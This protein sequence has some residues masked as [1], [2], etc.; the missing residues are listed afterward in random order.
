MRHE[1]GSAGGPGSPIAGQWRP[2][3]AK[4]TSW[5]PP[6]LLLPLVAGSW[7]H[8]ALGAEPP[9]HGSPAMPA[10]VAAADPAFAAE[11]LLAFGGATLAVAR[12]EDRLLVAE[13]ARL[14]EYLRPLSS[15][16]LPARSSALL[17]GVIRDLV[18][19]SGRIVVICHATGLVVLSAA[20]EAEIEVEQVIS[21]PG[22]MSLAVLDDGRLLLARGQG[23]LALFAFDDEQRLVR[24][25]AVSVAL[26]PDARVGRSK[27][28]QIA[29]RGG[30]VAAHGDVDGRPS[31]WLALLRV[32]SDGVL[33][34]A[35]FVELPQHLV[36]LEASESGFV[37]VMASLGVAIVGP[38]EDRAGFSV[39]ATLGE[40][41]FDTDSLAI[42]V[43]GNRIA[44]VTLDPA[45][46][47]E[48]WVARLVDVLDPSAPRLSGPLELGLEP[49]APSHVAGLPFFLDADT[50]LV[51]SAG[52]WSFGLD[53][54]IGT[55]TPQAY[56]SRPGQVHAALYTAGAGYAAT[57]SGIWRFEPTRPLAPE[58]VSR[59]LTRHLLRYED[60]I[61]LVEDGALVYARPGPGGELR[62][63]LRYVD[64]KMR[65]G[66]IAADGAGLFASGSA[67]RGVQR[68]ILALDLRG[69]D[70]AL[71]GA[72]ASD[73][74]VDAASGGVLASRAEGGVALIDARDP[75]AMRS[76]TVLGRSESH[77]TAGLAIRGQTLLR[78]ATALPGRSFPDRL[79]AF[80]FD[81]DGS[82]RSTSAV[83]LPDRARGALALWE[84][85]VYFG[86][87]GADDW[88]TQLG[89][90]RLGREGE[91]E[92]HEP[93]DVPNTP[94]TIRSIEL[95]GRHVLVSAREAG[96]LIVAMEADPAPIVLPWLNVLRRGG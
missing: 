29:V 5:L 70:A 67:P 41:L 27:V 71:L 83:A 17:P 21:D 18:A 39:L 1:L 28:Q 81:W 14:Q 52:L 79:E 19:V 31:P 8:S 85:R 26:A 48:R 90:A 77:G 3:I 35:G 62:E 34:A 66:S 30:W 43:H 53:A 44:A 59:S 12:H 16:A 87:Q 46:E 88:T 15:D 96:L 9:L 25:G 89:V 78:T 82:W 54:A 57:D 86:M 4:L 93:I 84:D 40:D 73:L 60:G 38:L 47:Q 10:Q 61:A 68:R 32:E 49:R 92:R 20:P 80:E 13:G 56:V 95:D 42:D 45:S 24:E 65:L 91:L 11:D 64:S 94:A 74:S 23:D 58:R 33:E 69:E 22:A 36:Q 72:L 75:G 51:S 55:L 76:M 50:L 7:Q 2:S 37:G 6:L 63:E